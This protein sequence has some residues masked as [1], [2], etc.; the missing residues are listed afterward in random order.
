MYKRILLKISGEQLAGEHDSGI[1]PKVVAWI[2]GEA[3]KVVD[4]GCQLIIIARCGCV[5]PY[6]IGVM[7]GA[8]MN[9]FCNWARLMT[10]TVFGRFFRSCGKN[11]K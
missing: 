10:N 3:K 1:D 9:I 7:R 2:A 5:M 4:A 11:L 8:L 6:V